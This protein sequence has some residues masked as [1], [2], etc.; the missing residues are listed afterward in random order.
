MA[1]I[2]GLFDEQTQATEAMDVILRVGFKDLDTRVFEPGQGD[3]TPGIPVIPVVPTTGAG[4]TGQTGIGPG[5]GMGPGIGAAALAGSGW[6]DKMEEVERAF[7]YEGLREGATLVVAKVDDEDA[8][9]VR[10][11]MRRSGARTYRE[12]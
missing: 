8:N 5:G 9:E 7:Y 10:E 4:G 12:D 11:L 3:G 1:V 2:A 6:F